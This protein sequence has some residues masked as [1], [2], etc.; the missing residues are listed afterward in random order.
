MH[1]KIFMRADAV[2]AISHFL[3]DWAARMGFLG[4]PEV[5]PNGVDVAAYTH[6]ISAEQ[7]IALRRQ[8]GFTDSDIVLVTTSRLSLKNGV[9]DL[10]RSLL[11][12]PKEYKTLIVG[13][14][15]DRDKLISLAVQKGLA[16]RVTFVGLKLRDE[17]PALLQAADIFVRPSLSEG[18]GISF[19]EALAAGLPIVGTPVGGIPDFLKDG[20][21]GVFAE[22]RNPESVAKAVIRLRNPDLRDRIVRKGGALVQEEYEWGRIAGRIHAMIRHLQHG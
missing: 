9:D 3:A 13:E 10:I 4:K 20:E 7:R 22:P 21:T 16:D 11:F 15:E 6:R 5:I 12:L 14:G 18:L 2:H 17:I 1:K 19:L 8:F